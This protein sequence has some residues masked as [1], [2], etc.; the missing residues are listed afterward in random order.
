MSAKEYLETHQKAICYFDEISMIISDLYPLRHDKEMTENYYERILQSD[1]R[2]EEWENEYQK[3]SDSLAESGGQIGFQHNDGTVEYINSKFR[4][5]KG[6]FGITDAENIREKLLKV[7]QEDKSF[8]HLF[9]LLSKDKDNLITQQEIEKAIREEE[10]TEKLIHKAF[11]NYLIANNVEIKN[12]II[13]KLK[14]ILRGKKGKQVAKVLC[15]MKEAGVIAYSDGERKSLYAS[16]KVVF[17]NIG[18]DE[19]INKQMKEDWK[20][21]KNTNTGLT[22]SDVEPY[23]NLFKKYAVT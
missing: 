10:K 16:M 15:G 13:E 14:E 2:Y 9:N 18:S 17:G 12:I 19:S 3:W 5:N 22:R 1:K 21:N 11:V 7:I 6:E 20:N 8:G 23:I 4:R